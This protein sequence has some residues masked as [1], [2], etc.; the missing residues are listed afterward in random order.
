MWLLFLILV[1]GLVFFFSPISFRIR[2][3]IFLTNYSGP[4]KEIPDN[5]LWGCATAAQQIESQ[6]PTDWTIFEKKCY[7]EKKFES[8]GAGKP[9]AGHIHRLGDY[10]LVVRQKKTN[11]DEL[12]PQD[13]T[14][15]RKYGQN[16]YRF[17]LDWARLFPK[18]GMKKPSS[19]GLDY[20]HKILE[21]CK[22]NKLTV[23][24]TLFH[25]AT[26]AWFWEELDGKRGWERND[27]LELFAQFVEA[28]AVNY[29]GDIRHFCTLNEPIVYLY[30]GYL[31]GVFPPLERRGD[32]QKLAPLVVR[33]LEAHKVAYHILKS[34]GERRNIPIEVGFTQHMRRFEPYRNWHALDRF[35]AKA[36][37]QVFEWDFCDALKTGVYHMHMSGFQ[38][39]IPG[40]K[41]TWDYLGINYYGRFYVKT[42]L[43]KPFAFEVLPHDVR[44]KRE[45]KS[46]LGWAIYPH[47][48]YLILKEAY[49]RYKK[50]IYILENGVA[51][52]ADDDKLRQSFLVEHI[53]EMQLA[54][55]EGVDVR[56]YFHWSL[57]DN[58]EWA[59]G[60]E[61]RFGL[62][63][64]DYMNN[65]KRIAR[66]SLQV[67]KK[68]IQEKGV[69]QELFQYYSQQG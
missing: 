7:A 53:R 19:Q 56:G 8:L 43:L 17:S 35:S 24:A 13:L 16:S 38:Q 3:N 40:L 9:K 58:F 28:V 34:Y 47:G 41:D 39:E 37:E 64:V 61:A 36:V 4:I 12:Y 22:K 50:P 52:S 69:S 30:Q 59:E 49:E 31:E 33:M 60:F 5:F 2:K 26:P 46:E 62:V 10:P 51:D 32:P 57:I 21:V 23:S 45:R 48:F 6:T 55:Q 66:K 14:L 20:Y 67:Y 63:K 18:K 42:N 44:N 54:M 65:F 27:A 1:V 11:F 68:I 25:F 15:A 29:L